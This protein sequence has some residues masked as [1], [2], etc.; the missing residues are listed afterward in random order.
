MSRYNGKYISVN[1][2]CKVGTDTQKKLQKAEL[3]VDYVK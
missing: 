1:L 2:N 3:F